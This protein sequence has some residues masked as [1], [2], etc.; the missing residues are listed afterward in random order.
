MTSGGAGQESAAVNPRRDLVER[1]IQEHAVRLFA[2]RGFAG[3]SL[4]DIANAAG[5]SR[6]ALYYYVDSKDE[7]LTTLVRQV[8]FDIADA[9]EAIGKDR[10]RTPLLRLRQMV[11]A[12]ALRQAEDPARFRLMLRSE[13]ELPPD[14][15]KEY[16]H[17]RRRVL[18]AFEDVISEGITDATLRPVDARVTALAIIGMVNWI[19]WWHHPGDA[20]SGEE[21]AAQVAE[22][23]ICGLRDPRAPG[24]E[25]GTAA[26][27]AVRLL[28]QDVQRLKKLLTDG[29]QPAP[30]A[31]R[32]RTAKTA[33]V[34][35]TPPK[36]R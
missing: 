26:E 20:R 13:A 27:H 23:A 21:I 36:T 28:E 2:E 12:G 15:A 24:L 16:E 30:P 25:A 7:L 31:R 35:R 14:I 19:A 33:R 9:L 34:K 1:Q 29:P 5:L 6:P 4:Q 8:T 18:A 17:G 11:H 32:P 10:G 22:F 3:T